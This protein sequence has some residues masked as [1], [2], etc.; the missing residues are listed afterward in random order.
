VFNATIGSLGAAAHRRDRV[1]L[2]VSAWLPGG[3]PDGRERIRNWSTRQRAADG[4][5]A[6][7]VLARARAASTSSRAP[8]SSQWTAWAGGTC[9]LRRANFA[10]TSELRYQFTYQGGATPEIFDFTGDDD[11]W[12]FINGKLAVDLGGLHPAAN[13]SITLDA[14]A[15][16]N[17]GLVVGGMY[18]IATFQAERHTTDSNYKLT[19]SNFVHAISQCT[20]TCNDGVVAATR[21][22][23]A[24]RQ[25]YG[26]RAQARL[27]AAVLRR[28]APQSPRSVTTAATWPPMAARRSSGPGCVWAPYCGDGHV[29]GEQCDDAPP[30]TPRLRQ[31]WPELRARPRC[32]DG[33]LQLGNGEECDDGANNGA[34]SSKCTLACKLKCGNG[35]VDAGEECDD[36]TTQNTGGYGKCNANCTFG[37]RCGDGVKNGSEQCDDGKNDGSYGTCNRLPLPA[38]AETEAD[39]PARDLRQGAANAPPRTV[40]GCAPTPHPAR[41]AARMARSA[42]ATTGSTAGNRAC[43]PDCKTFVHRDLQQRHRQPRRKCGDGAANGSPAASATFTARSSAAAATRIPASSATAG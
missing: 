17:L 3:Q 29:N 41:T 14:T 28:L 11:V 18:E 37:P 4:H 31:V 13:G 43:T 16:A 25:L 23:T 22:A 21:S 32:G 6:T 15:A 26:L 5:A 1:L 38:T 35:S 30:R 39:Q 9:S 2:V 10:F 8:R 19:L 7:L 42:A 12:V 34:T 27:R 24:A 20:T 33:A 40:R 36:G